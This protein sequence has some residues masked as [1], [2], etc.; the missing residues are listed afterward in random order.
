MAIHTTEQEIKFIERIGNF[1]LQGQ[2]GGSK[3]ADLLRG[4]IKASSKR[5]DWDA[6]DKGQAV[7]AAKEELW[8]VAGR[9]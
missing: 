7:Q 8:A 6:V 2:T 4:Y 3:K 5:T 9:S 1:S